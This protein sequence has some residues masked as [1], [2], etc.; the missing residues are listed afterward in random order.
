MKLT[1]NKRIL[2]NQPKLNLWEQIFVENLCYEDKEI[3]LSGRKNEEDEIKSLCNKYL[4]KLYQISNEPNFFDINIKD[5]SNLDRYYTG[6][7]KATQAHRDDIQDDSVFELNEEQ[8]KANMAKNFSEAQF[9]QYKSLVE[10]LKNCDYEP[11]FKALILR[12]SLKKCYKRELIKSEVCTVFSKRVKG[13]TISGLMVLNKDMLDFI[14]KNEAKITDFK[15]LYFEALDYSKTIDLG[16]KNILQGYETN[17]KGMWLKFSQFSK[18]NKNDADIEYLS[19]LVQG[20]QWCTK[21]TAGEELLLGDF[22]LFIDNAGKPHVGISMLFN[23][24]K[25]VRGISNNLAQEVEA[26]YRDVTIDFLDKNKNIQNGLLWLEREEWNRRL[27]KYTNQL[28][29]GS[30]EKNDVLYMLKDLVHG[31]YRPHHGIKNSNVLHLEEQ[32][33]NIPPILSYC[34]NCSSDQIAFKPENVDENTVVCWSDFDLKSVKNLETFKIYNKL[35]CV[36]GNFTAT[37][38]DCNFDNLQYLSGLRN[39]LAGCHNMIFPNLQSINGILLLDTAYNISFPNLI[40]IDLSLI[41]DYAQCIRFNKLNVI[42]QNLSLEEAEK[43]DLSNVKIVGKEVNLENAKDISLRSMLKAGYL[44]T[45]G[46][47]N[48]DVHNLVSIKLI[49]N[50]EKSNKLYLN[51]KIKENQY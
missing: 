24:L 34:F 48:I 1:I 32:F 12:E 20:T 33:V 43:I 41:A 7:L 2:I 38:T 50:I 5:N 13:Q 22:Y 11:S 8:V 21:S 39:S 27:I 17:G 51:S 16:K 31:D 6:Q 23:E 49:K 42:G 47:N 29:L 35:E 37:N 14:Y 30:M 4:E 45:K 18:G 25:E 10:L 26:E 28:K 15:T 46:A 40:N 9:K 19:R 36:Q 44:E 3:T